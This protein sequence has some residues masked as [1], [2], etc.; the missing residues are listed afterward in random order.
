MLCT[1]RSSN[2][3]TV[4]R[5]QEGTTAASHTDDDRIELPYT[6]DSFDQLISEYRQLGGYASRPST[7][8]KGT[9]YEATDLM[10]TKWFYDGT[11]WH[12]IKPH[13]VPSTRLVSLSGW[14]ALNHGT[15]SFTVKN[16]V[17]EASMPVATS[18]LRGHYK[19]ASSPPYKLTILVSS[20]VE[21]QGNL[22]WFVG[23]RINTGAMRIF[24]LGS[25]S[26]G[27]LRIE[28]WNSATSFSSTPVAARTM[29][30]SGAY[31]IRIEDDNTDWKYSLS[32]DG[33]N[34]TQFYSETRNTTFTPDQ[35]C[36]GHFNN[37][38]YTG[39][40]AVKAWTYAL[41]EG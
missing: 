14:T 38:Q 22:F 15:A 23:F 16:G 35:I 17:L 9:V 41:W 19:T 12:L 18:N 3:L 25:G 5:G 30:L 8:R 10:N 28:H 11:N 29:M 36:F 37:L 1:A 33:L 40:P 7:P 26:A 13:V 31:F 21:G 2:T 34:W 39:N 24:S 27:N 32:R 4:T 6:K 20:Q